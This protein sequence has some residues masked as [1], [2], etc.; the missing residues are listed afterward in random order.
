MD[1]LIYGDFPKKYTQFSTAKIVLLPVAYDGTSTYVKGSDK[2]PRAL[3]EASFNMEFYDIQTKSEVYKQGIYTAPELKGFNSPESMV[4][5][6]EQKVT[7]LLNKGK[8]VALIGG[9]HSVSIGSIYAHA[10]KYKDISI[11]QLDAH[12][13][14][15]EDYHDS[16]NNHACVMKRAKEVANIVQVGIRSSDVSELT[17]M[18]K[19]SIFFAKDIYNNKKWIKKA[20]SKLK[21]KVYLT[22][23]LDVFDPSLFPSTGTPEPGGLF[24]YDVIEFMYELFKNKEVVGLDL[25]ELCPK[26]DNKSPDFIASKLLYTLLTYKFALE[27]K[28]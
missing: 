12:S 13:D 25:V 15:R 3:I 24:W 23:D 5:N 16:K 18:E 17:A 9:E 4:A 11:L 7:E 19:G 6:V 1:E 27:K 8:F 22:I 10:K 28:K 26:E 21:K 14:L 20:I 2:G